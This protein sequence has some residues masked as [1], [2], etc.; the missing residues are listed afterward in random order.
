[1]DTNRSASFLEVELLDRVRASRRA[2][3]LTQSEVRERLAE[4]GVDLGKSA[5]AKLERGERGITFVE[6]MALSRALNFSVD[7]LIP[8]QVDE[9][10]RLLERADMQAVRV[11][12]VVGRAAA[13]AGECRAI[14]MAMGDIEA[15]LEKASGDVGSAVRKHVGEI[16]GPSGQRALIN[17][18]LQ[19]ENI[20]EEMGPYGTEYPLLDDGEARRG[21]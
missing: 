17:A 7:D 14:S 15:D 20:V 13:M 18:A 2:I 5:F 8:G 11:Q 3:G 21:P 12:D 19:L 9:S 16:V 4:L 1:M 6:A 10:D